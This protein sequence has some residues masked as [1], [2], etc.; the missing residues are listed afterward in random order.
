MSIHLHSKLTAVALAAALG[1]SVLSGVALAAAPGA[2]KSRT[3]PAAASVDHKLASV[4]HRG[5]LALHKG[6]A[7]HHRSK[8]AQ[9]CMHG[10]H[11][12]A[13]HVRT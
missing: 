6:M 2:P 13:K 10:R 8:V 4:E 1:F 12:L 11:K 3:T 9:H 5:H 7:A